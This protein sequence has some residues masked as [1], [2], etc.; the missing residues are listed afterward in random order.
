MPRIPPRLTGD[1]SPDEVS[2]PSNV[3]FADL[4]VVVIISSVAMLAALLVALLALILMRG[5]FAGEDW[6]AF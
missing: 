2:A 6:R 4:A 5:P 1:R 3:Q